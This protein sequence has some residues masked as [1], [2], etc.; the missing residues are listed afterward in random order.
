M[1]IRGK[2][3][4][5]SLPG[6]NNEASHTPGPVSA[7][8][9]TTLKHST[10]AKK[11]ACLHDVLQQRVHAGSIF[12]DEDLQTT[13]FMLYE[14]HYGDS[15]GWTIPGNGTPPCWECGATSSRF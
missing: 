4:D 7:A 2:Y 14:L 3:R 8:L 12:Y 1:A 5:T 9:V 10:S 6:G 15:K 13:L 11:T